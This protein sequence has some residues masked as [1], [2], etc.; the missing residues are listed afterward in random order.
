LVGSNLAIKFN[1]ENILFDQLI[2]TN[3]QTKKTQKTQDLL[4]KLGTNLVAYLKRQGPFFIYI[5]KPLYFYQY[6]IA[7]R[8]PNPT[9]PKNY[10]DNA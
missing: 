1:T 2:S 5:K 9:L 10:R 8:K 4:L 6:T 3:K 7:E